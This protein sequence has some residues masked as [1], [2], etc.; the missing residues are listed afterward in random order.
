MTLSQ[1]IAAQRAD[2][3]DRYRV[4]YRDSHDEGCPTRW[5]YCRAYSKEDALERFYGADEGWIAITVQRVI[6]VGSNLDGGR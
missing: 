2:K 5:W 3:R 4:L 6:L 1:K